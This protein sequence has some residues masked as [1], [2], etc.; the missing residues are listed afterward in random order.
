MK[1]EETPFDD[2][3]EQHSFN[4]HYL[5]AHTI[6]RH[7]YDAG[8]LEGMCRRQSDIDSLQARIDELMLEY[9][10]NEMTPEQV[11]EWAKNQAVSDI[12]LS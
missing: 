2:W 5:D 1:T 3:W 9:C 6:R 12:V 7:C 11:Q 8:V 4:I 10:P